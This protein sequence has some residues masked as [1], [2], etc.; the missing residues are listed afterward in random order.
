MNDMSLQ[1]DGTVNNLRG[2]K[3]M[4]R[5]ATATALAGLHRVL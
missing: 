3:F 5:G 1:L 4:G 2:S